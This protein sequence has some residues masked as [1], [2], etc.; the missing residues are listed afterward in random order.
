MSERPSHNLDSLDPE[1]PGATPSSVHEAATVPPGSNPPG[2]QPQSPHGQSAVAALGQDRSALGAGLRAPEGS[3]PAASEST[4]VRYFGDYVLE[5][6]LARGG[7]GVVYKGR[8]VNLNRPVALKMILA[9][10]LATEDDV[11]R[12][13]VEAEA[14]ANLDH[15]GIVPIYEVGQH[16]G[17]HYF[18][19]GYVEG[20]SLAQRVAAGPLPPREAAALMRE[21]SDAVQY[22]HEHGVIHRDLKPANVLLDAG[23]RPKVTDFG[24]AKKLEG[25]AGL[26]ASG[27]VMGTPAYMSPE[28][29][30][31][32]LDE[33]GTAADVY[34]LGA[35]LYC[36]LT[37][38]PPFQASSAIDTLLQVLEREPVSPRALN[39]AVD[40]DLETVCL[41]CLQKDR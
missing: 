16:E 24:L 10:Q 21:V 28:Q 14:A 29:A 15:P 23:G 25:D 31:G 39:P 6:E 1:R 22:A 26:T 9:G 20:Q 3:P 12:F 30:A 41:K 13:Y 2:D 36:L 18:S 19:M 17:Q 11:R 34:S 7:M 32:L 5:C 40:R 27:Q 38:R 4:R 8:Q 37:G 35:T 33:V